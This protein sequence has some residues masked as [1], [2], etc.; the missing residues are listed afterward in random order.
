MKRISSVFYELLRKTNE[1][2]QLHDE[3]LEYLYEDI[4]DYANCSNDCH[5]DKFIKNRALRMAATVKR[6]IESR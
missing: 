6:E 1:R 2:Q 3:D 5:R 4:I